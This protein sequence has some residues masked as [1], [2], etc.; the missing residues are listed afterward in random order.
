MRALQAPLACWQAPEPRRLRQELTTDVRASLSDT[1]SA[2]RVKLE[3]SVD[4]AFHVIAALCQDDF[5]NILEKM[6]LARVCGCVERRTKSTEA[7]M[8]RRRATSAAAMGQGTVL[9]S[10]NVLSRKAK[11]RAPPSPPTLGE[12]R[13]QASSTG[14]RAATSCALP[15]LPSKSVHDVV[16][17]L[18][19]SRPP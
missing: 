14:A 9:A 11:R 2:G 4:S 10:V 8:S 16:G 15:A 17:S 5:D 18:L 1:S 19:R 7:N 6:S 3:Q 12:A 13:P